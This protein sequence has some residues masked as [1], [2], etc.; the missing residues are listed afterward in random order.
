MCYAQIGG[1]ITAT[2]ITKLLVPVPIRSAKSFNGIAAK[3]M[4]SNRLLKLPGE[5]SPVSRQTVQT[6]HTPTRLTGGRD[7]FAEHNAA[8]A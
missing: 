7:R 3:L 1:L 6:G 5:R 4:Q 8:S 2:Y